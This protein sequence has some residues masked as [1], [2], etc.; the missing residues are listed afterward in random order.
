MQKLTLFL[1]QPVQ[2]H[3]QSWIYC[4]ISRSKKKQSDWFFES[5]SNFKEPVRLLFLLRLIVFSAAVTMHIFKMYQFS[6]RKL[7]VLYGLLRS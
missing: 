7:S 2:S 5:A 4:T 3:I 6:L 1:S